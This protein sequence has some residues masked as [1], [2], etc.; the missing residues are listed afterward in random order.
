[1]TKETAVLI[2]TLKAAGAEVAWSGCNPL[3]T[4]DDIAASLVVDDEL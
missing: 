3:S 4:S 1:M 2:K